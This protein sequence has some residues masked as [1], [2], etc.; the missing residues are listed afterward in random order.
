MSRLAKIVCFAVLAAGL[1]LGQAAEPT[2]TGGRQR[3]GSGSGFEQTDVFL[4]GELG[5]KE[6]RIPA[7]AVTKGG[8]L[9]AISEAGWTS[10]DAG[11]RD[12]LLRRSTDGGRT[13]SKQIQLILDKGTSRCGSPACLIDTKTGRIHL[14]AAVDSKRALH[15]YSDDDGRTWSEFVD[16]TGPFEAL[17]AK[18]AWTRFDTGPARGIELTRGKYRGRFVQPI[19]LSKGQEQYR[20]GVIYSDDRCVTWKP[21]GLINEVEYNTNECSVYEAVDGTLWM[22]IRGGDSLPSE[23]RKPYRLIATSRDGGLSWSRLR[24]DENL[25]GPRCL[26]STVRYSWPE[27]GRSRVLFANPADEKHR[28][29]MTVRLS[30]DDG[31]SWPVAKQIFAGPSAYSCLA[32]LPNGDIGLLYE[33]GEK[34]R[35]EKMT[36]AR[37]TLEWL[38][39]GKDKLSGKTAAITNMA[40]FP[41]RKEYTKPIGMK[42]VRIEPGSFMMGQ[43]REA[44]GKSI[45]LTYGDRHF[46]GGELDEQPV[47]KVTISKPFY[48][49]AT[50]VTNAQFEQFDAE[51]SSFRGRKGLSSEDDE[52]VVYVS[53][54]EAV[55]FCQ[56]LSKKER[57]PYRLPTEAEWEYACR[58]GTA[59]RFNTGDTLPEAYQKAQKH[60][61][62]PEKVST[63][64]GL[65][66]PNAWGLYDMHGNVEEWCY[67]WYGPYQAGQ[68]KDP[69]GRK[70]GLWK[71]VRG[72][73]HNVYLKSLRSANR[74]SG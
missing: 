47:H 13:W 11:D 64:V 18:W 34:Y 37:F 40:A 55:A 72:G 59:T 9:L 65:T 62:R 60:R 48:I 61:S 42:C 44:D 32:R 16:V 46:M 29:K 49:S 45:T 57:R 19:W 39:D 17:R 3:Q 56:W 2:A 22:N 54:H 12:I 25:I 63:R 52:A 36:F 1:H 23:G 27:E 24:H 28:I 41:A 70:S 33:R 69:V 66:A 14:L 68:Q 67:D 8:T 20:S 4:A 21:G 73:S 74:M 38:T 31:K 5:Y 30:Y 53:W 51:H 58:A 26:A 15:T 50:E 10:A 35:Y 7:L 6:F 43:E 71:V